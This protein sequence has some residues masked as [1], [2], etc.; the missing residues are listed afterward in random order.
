[1]IL[2]QQLNLELMGQNHLQSGHLRQLVRVKIKILMPVIQIIII[3]KI[4]IVFLK[5]IH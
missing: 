2:T 4:K 1:M 3:V 5:T